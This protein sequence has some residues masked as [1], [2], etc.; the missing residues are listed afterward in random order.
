MKYFSWII[1]LIM[2]GCAKPPQQGNPK[3]VGPVT[4]MLSRD[5]QSVVV[6]GKEA[7]MGNNQNIDIEA[8]ADGVATYVC[9]NKSGNCPNAANKITVPASVVAS[10][11]FTSDNNGQITFVLTLT[12]P[13]AGAFAC[14][15]GQEMK[16]AEVS[17]SKIQVVDLTNS[18]SVEA[19]PSELSSTLFTCP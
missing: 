18:I 6:S 3:F 7:G 11:T 17:Y 4:A 12:P 10:G 9:V 8:S 19:T 1:A 15:G 13:D 14:P 16:L 2:L 5:L